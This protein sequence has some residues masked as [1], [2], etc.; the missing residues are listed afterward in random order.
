MVLAFTGFTAAENQQLEVN[1][2]FGQQHL[3]AGE[4]FQQELEVTWYG[5]ESVAVSMNVMAFTKENQRVEDVVSADFEPND[6]IIEPGET[7]VVDSDVRVHSNIRPDSYFIEVQ[8]QA[9]KELEFEVIEETVVI[10]DADTDHLRQVVS[11]LEEELNRTESDLDDAYAELDELEDG[12]RTDFE[13]IMRQ[14]DELESERNELVEAVGTLDSYSDDL[15][16][17]NLEN[18]RRIDRLETVNAVLVSIVSTFVLGLVGMFL[19]KRFF[20]KKL[21]E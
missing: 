6:F 9:E 13:S 11:E 16:E 8:A 5:E 14:I 2:G 4:S 19:Y 7:V 3:V 1:P 15:R 20:S 12:A 10:E 18:E 21:Q 17:E